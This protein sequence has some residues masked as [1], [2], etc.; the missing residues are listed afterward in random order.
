MVGMSSDDTAS[1]RSTPVAAPGESLVRGIGLWQATALNMIDM[2]GVGPFV[3]IPLIISAMHGPQAMLG[4]IFGALLCVCDGLVWAELGAAM[5]QAGGPVRYLRAMYGP[6]A[7]GWLAFLFVFQLTFSAPLSMA[8]GAI[9]FA[10]YTEF[11]WPSLHNTLTA[12]RFALPVPLV[13]R[14]M[15]DVTITNGTFLAMATVGVA[16]ILLYRRITAIGKVGAFLWI[17]VILTTLSVIFTG[18][19]HFSPARAFTFPPGALTLTPAFFTGLGGALLIAVYDYWGYYNVCYLGGEIRDPGRVIPRAILLSIGG[20]AVLYLTMNI[21]ILGAMPWQDVEKS[22][23]IASDFMARF[24]GPRVGAIVT[25]MMLWTA[26]ASV[27]SLLLGYSRVPY[28]AAL[29]GDYF[30]VF[31]RVHPTHHFPHVSLLWLGGTAAVFCLFKLAD[32]VTALVVIRIST[33]FLAQTVGVMV[34]RRRRPDMPRPFRMW[35]YPVPAVLAFLG[36]IYVIIMR[37]KSLESI[38]LAALV[39]VVGTL[40]FWIRRRFSPQREQ[41]S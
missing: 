25:V 3:T 7:G 23:F 22:R 5:P 28:A 4:W 16:V 6:G 32:V 21:A 8:S 33:Q 29:E 11:L 36:F 24:W 31:A 12:Q 2:I 10:Q 41:E 27:F 40:L 17:G 34:L 20:V 14:T 39:V 1:L 37:P 38:R 9:G 15:I 13:G 26:F 18:V 35:L 19:T 30:K